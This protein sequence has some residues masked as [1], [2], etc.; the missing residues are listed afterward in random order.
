MNAI[1]QLEQLTNH[2]RKYHN[3]ASASL[4]INSHMNEMKKGEKIPQHHI[5]AILTDFINYIAGRYCI[6]YAIFASDLNKT[7]Q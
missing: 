7:N 3:K 6:D 2:A 1:D 4:E 5:D